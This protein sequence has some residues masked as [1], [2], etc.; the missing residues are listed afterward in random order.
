MSEVPLPDGSYDA[1]VVDAED[2]PDDQVGH[3]VPAR[4]RG[5]G[6]PQS[7]LVAEQR[8]QS[9][10]FVREEHVQG[11][12]VGAG[13]RA[14][15]PLAG[16]QPGLGPGDDDQLLLGFSVG[17]SH[18]VGARP[19][20]SG[21]TRQAPRLIAGL[22]PYASGVTDPEMHRTLVERQDLIE[23]R[24]VAVFDRDTNEGAPWTATL[25]T[26]PVD[27]RT[28]QRW[29]RAGQVVAAYRDRYQ[30]TDD[31]PL[32]A[33]GGSDA[34][35]IDAARAAAALNRAKQLSQQAP[36]TEQPDLTVEARQG[37]TL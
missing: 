18:A 11:R 8:L 35:K 27:A 23:R 29:R 7:V 15:V 30:I 6:G 26:K 33:G 32:G 13:G 34:Q 19:A 12:Y 3:V 20:G 37:R 22:I 28:A 24:A 31:Q 2:L 5:G 10:L 25:G 4:R 1:I 21:R 16:A 9:E 14:D 17:E 36:D